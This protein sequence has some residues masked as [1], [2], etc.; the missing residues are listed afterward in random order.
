LTV[1]PTDAGGEPLSGKSAAD[2]PNWVIALAERAVFI[3]EKR[4]K[5]EPDEKG[6]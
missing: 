5:A 6:R 3:Y 4:A 1:S 2:L